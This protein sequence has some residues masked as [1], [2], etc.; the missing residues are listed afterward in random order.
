MVLAK[1]TSKLCAL[2]VM[3]GA[4]WLPTRASRQNTALSRCIL[5]IA[6]L[7][8]QEGL[9]GCKPENTAYLA[10][11]ATVLCAIKQVHIAAFQEARGGSFNTLPCDGP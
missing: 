9:V 11:R 6:Q 2:T 3:G 4:L 1:S 7:V 10:S 5:Q 8:A